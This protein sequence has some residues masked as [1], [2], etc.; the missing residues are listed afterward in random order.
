V[1][2]RLN[3]P[4]PDLVSSM[5]V[6]NP[7]VAGIV[8][9][10][11]FVSAA[12]TDD[13]TTSEQRAIVSHEL[14]HLRQQDCVWN[15]LFRLACA[16]LWPQPLM[17]LVRRYWRAAS[18][19]VC[20]QW[21]LELD[22]PPQVY[23]GCL[24]RL[25][26][27]A[28]GGYPERVAGVGVL[29][30]R[31]LL[32]RRI[33]VILERTRDRTLGLSSRARVGAF[34]GVAIAA[35]VGAFIVS[36]ANSVAQKSLGRIAAF[37]VATPNGATTGSSQIRSTHDMKPHT[38]SILPALI[39]LAG[40]AVSVNLPATA[41]PLTSAPAAMIMPSSTAASTGNGA[42]SAN[43]TSTTM[44]HSQSTRKL[45][46]DLQNADVRDALRDLFKTVGA[47]Y[48]IDQDV[49]GTVTV[50][51]KDSD[52]V[53]A[54][55]SIV[56]AT[57]QPLQY[58]MTNGVFHVTVRKPIEASP[59]SYTAGNADARL[60]KLPLKHARASD[61]VSRVHEAAADGL[62][63]AGVSAEAVDADNTLLV[64]GTPED[65]VHVRAFVEN[66]D[67]APKEVC[68]SVKVVTASPSA[69][70]QIG[71]SADSLDG[72]LSRK[73]TESLV[74]ALANGKLPAPYIPTC[75][76]YSGMT[77]SVSYN[78]PVSNAFGTG[79]VT[80]GSKVTVTPI[81]NDDNSI[82]LRSSVESSETPDAQAGGPSTSE[83]AQTSSRVASGDTVLLGGVREH[84]AGVDV[85]RLVFATA[86][87]PDATAPT[88]S[89]T[90]LA[91]Q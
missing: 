31:S 63:P 73:D 39:A 17:W 28:A 59:G 60:F 3:V 13:F 41:T 15:L 61:L 48:T 70:A 53:T 42:L 83:T 87:L 4:Q 12:F 74:N 88:A 30:F 37:P 50:N 9:P 11:V 90:V 32:G 67:V 16:L 85:V 72:T 14:A 33:H 58:S 5:H 69:L 55:Q 57:S 79:F 64:R 66:L 10:T 35:L 18:E 19:M 80:V 78:A 44:D 84:A 46:L 81:V 8:R 29:S 77:A 22:C 2:A 86:T 91:G 51:L 43:S 75:R 65:F 76:T 40:G 62:V 49:T 68:V 38:K 25:A 7:F 23:A 89:A 36:P 34:G 71:L 56:R 27:R 20:D 54:L 6:R 47:N 82:S 1:S 26:D 52:I 45:S 21:V 24:L